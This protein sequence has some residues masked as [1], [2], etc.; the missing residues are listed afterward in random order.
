MA[1]NTDQAAP[2][3]DNMNVD[4]ISGNTGVIDQLPSLSLDIEDRAIIQNLD[5]RIADSE[6]YWNKADGFNLKAVRNENE[7]LATGKTE[8][9]GLYKHQKAYNEN[10]IYVAE[11]SILAYATSQVAGPAITPPS[12]ADRHKLFASDL[13]K[14]IKAHSEQVVDLEAMVELAATHILEKRIAIIKFHFDKNYGQKGEILAEVRDPGS[15]T[16]D[17]NAALGANPAFICDHIKSSA[18]E[19]IALWPNKEKEILA[20][21]GIQRRNKKNMTREVVYREV[22]VTHYTG[23]KPTEGVVWYVQNLVLDKC[24]NPNWLYTKEELNLLQFPKKPFIFG[25]LNNDGKHLIDRTTPLE[26]AKDMQAYLNRRG[27]QIGENA[28]KANGVLVISTDSGLTKDDAQNMTGDPNQKLVIKTDGAAVGNLVTQLQAQLLPDYVIKDKFDAR[29]QVGNIMGAPTD[30]TGAQADDGDPTLGEVMVKKNQ[31]SGRQDRLVRALTRMLRY[32]YQ[33]LVQMMI[34]WYD[35]EHEFN[36]DAGDGDFDI[37]T[38]K[39]DLIPKGIVVRAAKP[40]NPD[41]SRVEAI[42][43]K[44]GG[45]D[46]LSLL[47]LYKLLQL[48]NPQQLYDN[49][50]KQQ[51]DP[52]SLARDAL[53]TVDESRAYVAFQDIMNGQKVDIPENP[54][55]EYVLSLRKIMINDEFLNP[56]DKKARKYQGKFVDFVNKCIDSLEYRLSLEEAS[57]VTPENLRPEAPLQPAQVLTQQPGAA[58]PGM[59]PGM[60]PAPGMPGQMPPMLGMAPVGGAMAGMPQPPAPTPSSV[61]AGTPIP[62]PGQALT[63]NSTSP[64]ILP[65]L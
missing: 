59:A 14:A 9:K 33:Y 55:K 13:E 53:D 45:D 6:D 44:L 64:A 60:P 41:R 28:D 31:A 17:K 61:F 62:A 36:H 20:E 12:G 57:D 42:A 8:E 24:K 4:Q 15:V 52:A 30:F 34:V 11:E 38:M 43:L 51:S 48:D 2:V 7:R 63:A 10:Q 23:N 3:L 58:V 40:A 1:I 26:Q 46:K 32:Y 29:M 54:T 65:M 5:Q 49:W 25:N 18:E 56:K 27:R 39:R 16:L 47:D 50:A 22:W 19:L 21:L 37:I 35:E